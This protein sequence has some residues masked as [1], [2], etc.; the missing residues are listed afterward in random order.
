V[1]PYY[2]FATIEEGKICMRNQEETSNPEDT[3]EEA[4]ARA[5]LELLGFCGHYLHFHGGGRSGKASLLCTIAKSGGVMSQ[6]ELRMRF[7]LK[8]GS[9]SEILAKMEAAGMI[10]RT[11]SPEDRRQLFVKLTPQGT[12]LAAREQE[13]RSAFRHEASATLSAEEQEQLLGMLQKI[14]VSWEERRD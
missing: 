8:P 4:R 13:E 9:L 6:Q 7:E 2:I 3:P 11:R 14:R 10:E 12:E 5:I 1:V